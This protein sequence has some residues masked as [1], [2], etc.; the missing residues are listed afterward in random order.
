MAVWPLAACCGVTA[1]G[2]RTDVAGAIFTA[3]RSATS[4]SSENIHTNLKD[5]LHKFQGRWALLARWESR[6][7][8]D[9]H[10]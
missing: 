6:C 8:M 2:I 1:S 3:N 7:L 5:G 4:C 9:H 10:S